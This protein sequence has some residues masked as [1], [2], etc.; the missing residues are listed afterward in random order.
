MTVYWLQPLAWWGLLT[1]ALPI[2]IH[3]LVRHRSRRLSFPSIRF[4]RSTATVALRRRFISDWPLL[5]TRLAVL[6]CAVAALAAPAFVT[7]ARRVAWNARVARAII[8]ASGTPAVDQIVQAERAA[9]FTS[10]VFAAEDN[11]PGAVRDAVT[12]LQHQAPAARELVIVGDVRQGSLTQGDIDSIARDIGIRFRLVPASA[13]ASEVELLAVVN[14]GDAM[15]STARVRTTLAEDHTSVSYLP[16]PQFT[17]EHITVMAAAEHQEHGQAVLRAVLAEGVVLGRRSDRRVTIAFAAAQDAASTRLKQPASQQW[18]RDALERLPDFRGGEL[19]GR[20]IVFVPVPVTDGSAP[21][22]VARIA[23]AV[24]AD[25]LT[26]M[27][28]RRITPSRLEAWTRSPEPSLTS[29]PPAD[30]SD[31]RWLWALTLILLAVEQLLRRGHLTVSPNRT[32]APTR[33]E[34]VRVA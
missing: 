7:P 20:L 12:W 23:S 30:E 6:A 13:K 32:S 25:D 21:S 28:P 34:E 4:L 8:A 33:D 26:D 24:F 27:E 10:A 31:R 14:R 1:L 9:T 5:V 19:E 15:V 17:T 16:A 2:L 22:I 29:I 18:M 11:V 3:L